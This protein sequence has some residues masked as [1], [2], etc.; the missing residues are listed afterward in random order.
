V[1]HEGKLTTPIISDISNPGIK[2]WNL[3]TLYMVVTL[4]KKIIN[5]LVNKKLYFV[6]Q[7]LSKNQLN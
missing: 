7:I 3:P 6:N 5:V 2:Y 4:N 1:K